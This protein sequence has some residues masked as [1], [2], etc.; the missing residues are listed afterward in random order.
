MFAIYLALTEKCCNLPFHPPSVFALKCSALMGM[1]LLS[2]STGMSLCHSQGTMRMSRGS[3]TV[4]L[5]RHQVRSPVRAGKKGIGPEIRGTAL[6]RAASLELQWAQHPKALW[7]CNR[8]E[9]WR[10]W[11]GGFCFTIF[12]MWTLPFSASASF[13]LCVSQDSCL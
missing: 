12:C 5:C 8:A 1:L 4:P 3:C 7:L 10:L 9:L 13:I 2:V 6:P 11:E